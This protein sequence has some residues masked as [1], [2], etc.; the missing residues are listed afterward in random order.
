MSKVLKLPPSSYVHLQD[1]NLSLRKLLTGP[2]NY[3][4]LVHESTIGNIE[5]FVVVPPSTYVVVL[6][7]AKRAADGSVIK[8]QHGQVALHYGGEEVRVLV[9][10]AFVAP[11]IPLFLRFAATASHFRSFLASNCAARRKRCRKWRPMPRCC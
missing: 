9:R 5:P 7:P 2:I 4:T 10:F 6:N 8:D 1:S 11:V 3:T